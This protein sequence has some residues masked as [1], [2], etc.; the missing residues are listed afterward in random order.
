[1]LAELESSGVCESLDLR[2]FLMLPMQRIT[3][4]PLL[5]GAILHRINDKTAPIFQTAEKAFAMSSKVVKECNESAKRLERIE[6]MIE[7]EKHFIYKVAAL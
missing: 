7:L 2:S 6:Q 3:R 4:Y 5:A 1:M